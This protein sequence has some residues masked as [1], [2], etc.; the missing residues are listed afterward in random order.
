M[1]IILCFYMENNTV[2]T[3]INTHQ[4]MEY[5]NIEEAIKNNGIFVDNFGNKFP[6][7]EAPFQGDDWSMNCRHHSSLLNPKIDVSLFRLDGGTDFSIPCDK[8]RQIDQYHEIWVFY[9]KDSKLYRLSRLGEIDSDNAIDYDFFYKGNKIY[10]HMCETIKEDRQFQDWEKNQSFSLYQKN[11]KG[12]YEK[13]YIFN[14][15]KCLNKEY[16]INVKHQ[17]VVLGTQDKFIYAMSNDKTKIYVC[18]HIPEVVTIISL[19]KET[20]KTPQEIF[21]LSQQHYNELKKQ[22][23]AA[24][25]SPLEQDIF[26]H[27]MSNIGNG[28]I[29]NVRNMY[30]DITKDSIRKLHLS[31]KNQK[32]MEK[33]IKKIRQPKTIKHIDI[34]TQ[35]NVNL[36][37]SKKAKYKDEYNFD[38]E[39]YQ[40][41]K[42]NGV[43][44][45]T[46]G[47][48]KLY[49]KYNYKDEYNFDKDDK[50]QPQ[51]RN[52]AR[53]VKKN[54]WLTDKGWHVSK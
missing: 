24:H 32:L 17:E 5:T 29:I 35:Y 2:N 39:P 33:V 19:P 28:E 48:F 49:G 10:I 25:L 13:K 30:D 27:I 41:K 1:C 21:R 8:Q 47:K 46:N 6:V 36:A 4:T 34:E 52:I 15:P 42:T 31:K 38:K 50:Y 16:P 9:G 11:N 40:S 14:V 7:R 44:E 43:H 23:K 54:K 26:I 45:D 20:K 53:D 51:V 22:R 12:V 37:K 18:N 3:H